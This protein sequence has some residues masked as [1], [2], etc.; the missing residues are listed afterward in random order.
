MSAVRSTQAQLL[1]NLKLCEAE[2]Q[3]VRLERDTLR[4]ALVGVRPLIAAEARTRWEFTKP[5][6][7][8]DRAIECAR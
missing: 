2:L 4:K 7:R 5:L 6:E 1:A 3:V 8:I